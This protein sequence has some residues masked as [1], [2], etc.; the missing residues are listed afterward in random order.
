MEESKKIVIS[1]IVP[2]YNVEAFIVQCL[3]TLVSAGLHVGDYEIIVVNDGSTDNTLKIVNDYASSIPEIKVVTQ[4]NQGVSATRNNAIELAQGEYIHFVDSDDYVTN[5]KHL[6]QCIRYASK[7]N[8]DVLVF[9]SQNVSYY[10]LPS[11][12]KNNKENEILF[13][14]VMDGQTLW[15]KFSFVNMVWTYL[16]KRQFIIDNNLLFVP[17]ILMEDFKYNI[18]VFCLAKRCVKADVIIYSYRHNPNSILHDSSIKKQ[19]KLIDGFIFNA[20]YYH[21]I[22]NDK[23]KKLKDGAKQV[24]KEQ[25][26]QILLFGMMRAFKIDKIHYYITELRKVHLYPFEWVTH[27]DYQMKKIKLFHMIS[28]HELLVVFLSK[29][30]KLYGKI[31]P[32]I[33]QF[34]TW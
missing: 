14:D 34:E 8:L 3:Q 31:N 2:A 9:G 27:P 6:A 22:V 26:N 33:F 24:L 29:L 21:E 16:I 12:E 25:V 28:Q 30:F 11:N 10:S 19:Q 7:N 5:V 20:N 13:S 18:D 4:E 15:E 32:K 1:W 23:E 17:G